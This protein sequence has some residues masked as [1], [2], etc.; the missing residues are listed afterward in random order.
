MKLS[1]ST[2]MTHLALVGLGLLAA[3]G[4]YLY[5]QNATP[6]M[7]G[8][9]AFILVHVIAAG[10]MLY[11]GR[12][13]L[14]KIM[15]KLH[16]PAAPHTHD[17]PET[18]GETISWAF[19]YDILLKVIFLNKERQFREAVV[20]LAEIQPGEKVLDV[21]CGSGTLTMTAKQQAGPT[22]EVCG[23]DAAPEMIGRARQKAAQAGLEI[24]FRTGLAEAIDFPDNSFDVVLSS[25]MVHHLPGDLK[26]KTFAEIYR[27]LKPGGRLLVVDFEPPKKG[28][29]ALILPLLLGQGMMMID[30]SDLP[31][32]LEAAGFTVRQTGNAGH[33]LASFVSGQKV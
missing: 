22:V 19:L 2:L 25:F 21:G 20:A 18:A 17:V 1:K 11:F 4:L 3:A 8:L 24:D 12:G 13:F 26:S 10:G 27:V 15:Q 32:L 29:P 6:V 5:Y 7:L 23:T 30:N 9:V 14:L 16:Q 28:L 33:S 31:P